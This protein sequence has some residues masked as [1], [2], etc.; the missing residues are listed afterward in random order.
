MA[1]NKLLIR[2]EAKMAGIAAMPIVEV[3]LL[4][5]CRGDGN[6]EAERKGLD[7]LPNL[8]APAWAT[9]DH[10]RPLGTV[11][12]VRKRCHVGR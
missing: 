9:N 7:L 11:D 12:P 2:A 1:R 3:I 8:L 4:S 5:K 10:Q 6:V